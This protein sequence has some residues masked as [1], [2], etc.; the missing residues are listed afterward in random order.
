MTNSNPKQ[1]LAKLLVIPA[2][3]AVILAL[4]V[5]PQAD[6]EPR[7]FPIGI[8]GPP[9]ETATLEA[10]LAAKD[11]GAFDV[12][13]YADEASAVA[14]IEDRD[15]Y[16][17]LVVTP[18]GPTLLTASAAGNTVATTLELRVTQA[19][20]APDAPGGAG[21]APKVID[22]VAADD[23][24]PRGG[25]FNAAILPLLIGGMLT[26]T[27]V[28]ML[29][30]PGLKQV[31]VLAGAS[32]LAGLASIG[33]IQGWLGILGGDWLANA[34]VITL[35]VLAVASVATAL[36][37]LMGDV[38]VGVA[39]LLMVLI[40]NPWSGLSS[41]PELMPSF[42]GDVGQLFVPGAG[43]QALR[44]T[45]F[46]DGAAL[47]EHLTVLFAWAAIG[48]AL[49]GVAAVRRRHSDLALEPAVAT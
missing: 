30:R 3:V 27:L 10:Q 20:T 4:F 34:G 13:R 21:V 41:A 16:G 35:M 28:G 11:P 46:F 39:A 33:I 36:K 8:A 38:G 23:N 22:V 45:A 17:A 37:A 40:G 49:V 43:G 24:D 18:D 9:K 26:A 2:A 25:G 47:G 5:F 32:T 48:V 42:I 31:G 44:D 7:D 29:T 6:P 14:A 12:H 19:V 1:A 15:V